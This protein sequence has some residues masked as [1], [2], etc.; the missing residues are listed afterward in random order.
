MLEDVSGGGVGSLRFARS[1]GLA[2]NLASSGSD[3]VG[4]G[5]DW[6]GIVAGSSG[7]SAAHVSADL[8]LSLSGCVVAVG[9]SVVTRVVVIGAICE[10]LGVGAGWNDGWD[11]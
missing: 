6:A 10:P 7:G 1:V 5:R 11:T 2:G 3:D 4:G 9:L 8:V